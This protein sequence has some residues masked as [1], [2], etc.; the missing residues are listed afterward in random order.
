MSQALLGSEGWDSVWQSGCGSLRVCLFWGRA[1]VLQDQRGWS[2]NRSEHG[3]LEIG[4][5]SEAKQE[6]DQCL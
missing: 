4:V 1:P 2:L 3:T 6:N 5:V